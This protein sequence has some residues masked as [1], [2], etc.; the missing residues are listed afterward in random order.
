MQ[1]SIN[2]PY[3]TN[4]GLKTKSHTNHSGYDIWFMTK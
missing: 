3:T 1:W 2:V 4:N